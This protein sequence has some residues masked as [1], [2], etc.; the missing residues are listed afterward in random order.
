MEKRDR[1]S[2]SVTERRLPDRMA[3]IHGPGGCPTGEVPRL[4]TPVPWIACPV[5][6]PTPNVLILVDEKPPSYNGNPPIV[7]G[8]R[9][10][11]TSGAQA[12]RRGQI[13]KTERE[14]YVFGRLARAVPGGGPSANVRPRLLRGKRCHPLGTD[15]PAPIYTG[16][17]SMS[18]SAS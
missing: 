5:L 15:R 11:V 6:R 2:W 17:F 3:K 8:P 10:C 7:T 16:R 1:H 12:I 18:R 14:H 13:T 4:D 9:S